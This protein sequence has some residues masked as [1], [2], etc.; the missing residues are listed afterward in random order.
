MMEKAVNYR[1]ALLKKFG[2]IAIAVATTSCASVHGPG[3]GILYT[4]LKGPIAV[5]A[6][7]AQH[8]SNGVGT[9]SATIIFGLFTFGDA[10]IEAAKRQGSTHPELVT[11]THVD[12]E[13]RQILGIGKFT[14]RV[15][16]HERR[17]P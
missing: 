9:A 2:A 14:V 8:G 17:A 16:F 11:V 6:D 12:Y 4:N 7:A 13:W 15:Y 1:H 10:S 5:T 3:G